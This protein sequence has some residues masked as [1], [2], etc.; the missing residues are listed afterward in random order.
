MNETKG[1]YYRHIYVFCRTRILVGGTLLLSVGI[2][3][4]LAGCDPAKRYRILT[5]FFDGVPPLQTEI[6]LR[7]DANS[8]AESGVIAAQFKGSRHE[9]Y[10]RCNNCHTTDPR[11]GMPIL[12][13]PTPQLCYACHTNYAV[14]PAFVHG[15][16]AVGACLVCHDPHGSKFEHLMTLA[17]PEICYQCHEQEKVVMSAGH[18]SESIVNCTH[19]HD[20]HVGSQRTFLKTF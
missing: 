9:P 10:D 13:S 15:P 11:S 7:S 18:T 12:R 17:Q 4:Y 20:P 1:K 3:I 8:H 16:V 19:C 2:C 5:F 14:S 6:M